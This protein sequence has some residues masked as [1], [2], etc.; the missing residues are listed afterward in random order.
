MTRAQ[1]L[2]LALMFLGF[3]FNVWSGLMPSWMTTKKFGL[4][5][6]TAEDRRDLKQGATIAAVVIVSVGVGMVLVFRKSR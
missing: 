3:A 6:G 4:R 5:E 1:K 2:G